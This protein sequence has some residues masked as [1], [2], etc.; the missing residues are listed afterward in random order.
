[1]KDHYNFVDQSIHEVAAR[2]RPRGV[3]LVLVLAGTALLIP[4][5]ASGSLAPGIGGGSFLVLVVLARFIT[6]IADFKGN[7]MKQ[8]EHHPVRPVDSGQSLGLD[9]MNLDENYMVFDDVQSPYGNIDQVAIGKYNGIFLIERLAQRGKAGFSNGQL[10][11]NG[12]VPEMNYIAQALRNA[13]WLK[14]QIR[15]ALHLNVELQVTPIVLFTNA[16][17]EE[18][19]PIKGVVIIN[20]QYLPAILHRQNHRAINSSIWEC[21]EKICGA[22]YEYEFGSD[23]LPSNAA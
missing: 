9:L 4:L 8:I 1:M 19:Q 15:N 18:A 17:V 10:I 20:W 23:D 22:V 14:D 3:W 5:M 7:R 2:R 21:R 13:G 6:D 16:E 12:H 11:V